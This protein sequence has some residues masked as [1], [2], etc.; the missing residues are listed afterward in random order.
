MLA[1]RETRI[2][3][4]RYL[5]QTFFFGENDEIISCSLGRS[6]T[7]SSRQETEEKKRNEKAKSKRT[8]LRLCL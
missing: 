3:T 1:K 8:H 4:P 6:E 7:A 5:Y 2:I